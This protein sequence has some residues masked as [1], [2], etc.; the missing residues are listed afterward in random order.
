MLNLKNI[1]IYL[2]F[3]INSMFV[4]PLAGEEGHNSKKGTS[5]NPYIIN[6]IDIPIKIDGNLNERAWERA[7][8]ITL[9][10]EVSP[11]ENAKPPVKTE[12]LLLY[13]KSY[14]Y[15]GFRCFD[16]HPRKIRAH[17]GERDR[18][19]GDDWVAVEIDTFNDAKRA[20]TLF[21]TPFGVQMDGISN[22]AGV[23][24]YNWDTIYNTAGK[25]TKW[26]YS[27]EIAIPFSSLRFQ[28]TKD[29]QTWGINIVR[30]YPRDISYQIWAQPFDRSNS[31]RVCQYLKIRGFKNVSPGKNLELNPTLTSQRT[32]ER[33]NSPDDDFSNR[34]KDTQFGITARWGVTS[35]LV[36]SATVNPDFSQVEA[37]AAQL[38][39]NQPFAL[40][41]D[42]R[43]P[44]FTEG[45]DFFRSPLNTIY[46][47]VLR[48]PQWGIKLSGKE[49][50]NGLGFYLVKDAVTNLIFPGNQYS[51][52]LSIPESNLSGVFRYER[53]MRNH[54][55]LGFL[56]TNR[57]GADYYNRVAGI[58]GNIRFSKKDEVGFQLLG[59]MTRYS[60]EIA[61]MADQTD[62][63]FTGRAALISY[64]HSTRY[65]QIDMGYQ[66]I[67]ED[68]R[69]DLGFIPQVGIN[70]YYLNSRYM[71]IPK[72]KSWWSRF[73]LYNY[74]QY[75]LDSS[76]NLLKKSLESIVE[77]L[78][79]MQS[80]IAVSNHIST[81]K[82]NGKEF[83]LTRFECYA[84]VRPLRTISFSLFSSVGQGIDYFN[85]RRGN[86]VLIS[87]TLG[88]KMGKH[89]NLDLSHGY[90]KMKVSGDDL[91]TANISEASLV[92]YFNNRM[93]MRGILQ[94]FDYSYNE[95]NFIT[96][97]PDDTKKLFSQWLFS[98]R[99]NPRTVLFLGYTDN[100]YGSREFGIT[101]KDYTFFLK[102]GYAWI[103]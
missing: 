83:D 54:S 47:R 73:T 38:D 78:G 29:D 51:T 100:Y 49:K 32:D 96:G 58:D 48:D 89:L 101:K 66:G 98:Y 55:T 4:P 44:F 87:P 74:A 65:H 6:A 59:S 2:I 94:Y 62:E 85:T 81:E 77:F 57:D 61:E 86:R 1:V 37:D 22:S 63:S 12:A 97:V 93:F 30:G 18:L 3:I 13:D 95:H 5:G 14:F 24:D 79:G 39:I 7:E 60:P 70:K 90:E 69:A 71:W 88:F 72:K 31:C 35:N 45:L 33:K 8:I 56:V 53:D 80:Q 41:Y 75:T 40:F 27:I 19:S 43:R 20:F 23:K 67:G 17:F 42:E 102:I 76:R 84:N 25:I 28:H 91:F 46:S 50:R 92:Y 21:S 10:Y 11:G 82:Y 52:S 16:P 103:M 9:N 68:F 26:G 99:I 34:D 64:T 15:I 36:L